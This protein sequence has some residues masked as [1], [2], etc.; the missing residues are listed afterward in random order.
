MVE[1][2]TPSL[3]SSGASTSTATGST[4]VPFLPV[5]S[6]ISCSAQ[7]GKPTM[8]EPS[9]VMI[10][11]SRPSLAAS[12]APSHSA[13][14]SVE[15]ACSCRRRLGRLVEQLGDV[16]AGQPGRHQ[17]ERGQRA[18]PPA[19]VRVGQERLAVALVRRQLLERRTRVGHDDDPR[20]RV[21]PGVGERLDERTPLAVGLDR[22]AGLAGHHDDGP[23]Q[24]AGQR[25]R[26]HARVGRVEHDELDAGR[27][28]DDLGRQRRAA[29]TGQH[30]PV[31][32][33]GPQ[34]GLQRL[35]LGQ[36]RPRGL[37]QVDPAEP[38]R[39]LGLGL[40]TPDASRPCAAI[41]DAI[42]SATS[43]ST[44][45]A[46]SPFCVLTFGALTWRHAFRAAATVSC[47]SDQEA[48]NFSDAL[49]LEHLHDL[50]VRDAELL[51]VVD[52]LAVGRR[53]RRGP[54]RR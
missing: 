9:A 28:G 30:D 39:R 24:V 7:S 54:C 44:T 43:L 8:S 34:V 18:V 12:T 16:R 35:D 42:F 2:R 26:D 20:R 45:S 48:S 21:D 1:V 23:L 15:S 53:S 25:P 40:R 32:A 22:A 14:L 13:G 46:Q 11:L 36:Q 3:R 4:P 17:A 5:L 33:L 10:A 19:D 29:H 50:V 51:Q 49:V 47:S 52:H 6:A 37:V 38:D 31:Q 27:P 41:R